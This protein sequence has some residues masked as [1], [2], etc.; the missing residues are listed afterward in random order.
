MPHVGELLSK[1]E[2]LEPSLEVVHTY[3]AKAR[4]QLAALPESDGRTGL[5]GLADY[6][7]REAALLADDV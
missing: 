1:Y 3:L 7:D 6:L 4:R 5:T 2:T